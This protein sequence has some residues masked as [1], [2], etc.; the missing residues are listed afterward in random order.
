MRVGY[1]NPGLAYIQQML[2]HQVILPTRFNLFLKGVRNYTEQ[3][4]LSLGQFA[5][6]LAFVSEN[7][8]L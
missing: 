1:L 6:G 8:L 5:M 7:F 2:H 3:S 4:S